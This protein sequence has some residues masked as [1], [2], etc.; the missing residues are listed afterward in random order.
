MEKN[1]SKQITSKTHN[2]SNKKNK[3]KVSSPLLFGLKLLSIEKMRKTVSLDLKI[4]P[5][6]EFGDSQRCRKILGLS[7]HILNVV[8]DEKGNT[9]HPTDQIKLKEIKFENF[10]DSYNILFGKL[11]KIKAAKRVEAIVKSLDKDH[12]TREAYR[13]LAWIE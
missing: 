13:L 8:E 9:F 11:D 12:I 2:K 4:R 7:Q 6:N 1:Q 3:G 5:F 10:D